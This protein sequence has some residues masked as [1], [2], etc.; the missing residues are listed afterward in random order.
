MVFGLSVV[1]KCSV[2]ILTTP[3]LAD[4]NYVVSDGLSST[5][6]TAFTS[7]VS[8]CVITYT[9]DLGPGNPLPSFITAASLVLSVNSNSI[10]DVGTYNVRVYG[11]VAGFPAI[12]A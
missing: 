4:I 11:E 5:T 2:T 8:G 1:D 7:S 12:N 9:I 3:T 6:I 10:G